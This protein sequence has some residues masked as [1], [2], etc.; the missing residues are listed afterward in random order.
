MC[1]YEVREG[2]RDCG[3][4]ERGMEGRWRV[5]Q[6]RLARPGPACAED[7]DPELVCVFVSKS[8]HAHTHNSHMCVCVCTLLWRV[9]E[10][11]L[12]GGMCAFLSAHSAM[13]SGAHC[14]CVCARWQCPVHGHECT[15]ENLGGALRA[16]TCVCMYEYV[17]NNLH[18]VV[19]L[20]AA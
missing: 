1:V 7:F 3:R 20:Y 4:T 9:W 12:V 15:S 10:T 11:H 13:C 16:H 17:F 6:Q 14:V 19:V 8:V 18:C 5:L 2:E